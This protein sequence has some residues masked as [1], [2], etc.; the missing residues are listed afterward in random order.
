[1]TDAYGHA[2]AKG[3]HEEQVATVG[4]LLSALEVSHRRWKGT[5]VTLASRMLGDARGSG[6]TTG[7]GY[8]QEWVDHRLFWQLPEIA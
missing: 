2:C 6:H 7:V 1:M 3:R 4:G 5:H 8:L